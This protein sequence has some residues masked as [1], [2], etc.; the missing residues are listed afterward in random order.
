M[1]Y[2]DWLKKD[3]KRSLKVILGVCLFIL[4]LLRLLFLG[5]SFLTAT[6]T[7]AYLCTPSEAAASFGR[8]DDVT[9]ESAK[10]LF[11]CGNLSTDG[12]PASLVIYVLT[13]DNILMNATTVRTE[14]GNVAIPVNG[15]DFQ[16]GEYRLAVS[17]NKEVLAEF[18]IE[19]GK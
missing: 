19:I 9:K 16:V 6:M 12:R 5:D 2:I 8:I 13:P 14:P 10:E 1:K 3:W 15:S 17:N 7:E 18:F 4:F 11:I